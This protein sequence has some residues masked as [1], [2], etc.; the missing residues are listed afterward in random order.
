MVEVD[1]VGLEHVVAL[2]CRG[3]DVLINFA[4]VERGFVKVADSQ[5]YGVYGRWQEAAAPTH[6]V[7]SKSHMC[8]EAK[9]EATALAPAS[10]GSAAAPA[11]EAWGVGV[12]AIVV[13]RHFLWGRVGRL[14]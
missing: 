14:R 6:K 11:S 12:R 7:L 2:C 9:V 3:I 10:G 5:G 13:S 4:G 1:R 8:I